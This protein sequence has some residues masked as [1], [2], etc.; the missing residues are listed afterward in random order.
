MNRPT[1]R[2]VRTT[3]PVVERSS[4]YPG[5]V[6]GAPRTS[7]YNPI[8][9]QRPA[10]PIQPRGRRILRPFGQTDQVDIDQYPADTAIYDAGTIGSE[11]VL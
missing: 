4:P 9:R 5:S 2:Y 10:G 8:V 11:F 1:I 7:P 6:Q 3:S